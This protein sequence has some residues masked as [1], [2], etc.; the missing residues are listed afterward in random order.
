MGIAGLFPGS[1]TLSEFWDNIRAGIDS[2]TEVP[3]G[4][5]LIEP[6]Q[7]FDPR[8]G[9]P[10]HVYS[11][12]GGFVP[13]RHFDPGDLVIA[14]IPAANLDPVFQLA[15]HVARAAWRDARTERRR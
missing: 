6:D 1:E 2:T 8:V 13:R 11:K 15:L 4:R 10:D 9:L 7:A 12:R 5:W 14:G 3:E